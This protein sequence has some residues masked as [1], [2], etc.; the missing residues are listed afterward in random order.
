MRFRKISTRMLLII[1]PILVIGMTALN[2]ISVSNSRNVIDE[3]IGYHM[4][5]E[6]KAAD[7]QI[8][9]YL[10]DIVTMAET[11]SS[12]VGNTYKETSLKEY[13]TMLSDVIKNNDMVLG[14]GLWF[15]PYAYDAKQEYVGPYVYKEGNSTVVTYDYSNAE[16]DYFN[17]EYYMAVKDK[18][19]AN[20]TDPYY[21]ETSGLVMSSCS[22]PIIVDGKFIGCVTVDMELSTVTEVIDSIKVGKK[23]DA[24]LLD[25]AGVY[26]AGVSEDVI[27]SATNITSDSNASLAKAGTKILS[28]ESGVTTCKTPELGVA[29]L[30]YDTLDMTDWKLIIRMP[31]SEINAPVL[32]L[33]IVLAIVTI[34]AIIC[35][36]VIVVLQVRSI[37]NG[38]NHVKTF[39]G[40][41]AEGD[42]SIEPIEVKRVD[43][44]G[45]MSS[46]LNNMYES[47]R[48]VLS[49]IA[50]YA[51]EIDE[52]S[53]RLNMASEELNSQFEN[54]QRLMISV[55]EDMMT[56][57]A[58][59]EQVNASSEEVLANVSLLA[60]ETDESMEMSQE[61][62][63]RASSIE[64]KSRES[65]DSAT[66]LTH[67]IE[68]RLNKSIEN[69]KVVESITELTAVI[70]DIAEQ[71][72]LL[73]LNAS[74]EAARAGEA[75]RGFAVVA[76][77]IG[78]L[79][80]STSEAVG[81]IQDTIADVQ[82]A[83]ADLIGAANG[84]LE[85][86]QDTVAP[87]YSNFVEVAEQY[88]QDAVNF[89]DKASNISGMSANIRQI[90]AEV[91]N[92]IQSVAEA[93]QETSEI[94]GRI[95]DSISVASEHVESVFSMST[96]QQEIADTLADTVGKFKLD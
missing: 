64:S 23:G 73:S 18:T 30:Y 67:E 78:S 13:E 15:E 91:T 57:S 80:G 51:V 87:D 93:T 37:S 1:V 96:S 16:Y 68:D 53:K 49:G 45:V 2:L 26:L 70:S 52:S 77:E 90:M 94:S 61:I 89:E 24:M 59:T 83:F 22:M 14:S 31:Q 85:F 95:R 40:S 11:I 62:K 71:I 3:Q 79:A 55:N 33:F 5:S 63:A 82:D 36:I 20:I 12:T 21:D 43:E 29:N 10:N 47:N 27:M 41:L 19:D 17:Q 6:L 4:N 72:N 9:G 92:A 32:R 66:K 69:A 56:T 28:G 60:S 25:S 58:A 50:R 34:L 46:S 76:S 42:F 84:L 7:W 39:A 8:T 86:L 81:Q 74:I 65:Y 48:E 54:V 88:G 35:E 38:I 44:L 75:G